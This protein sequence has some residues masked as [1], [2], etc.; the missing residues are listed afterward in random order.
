MNTTDAI[1]KLRF[2]ATH[3]V[4]END[5]DDA[6]KTLDQARDV[7]REVADALASLPTAQGEP[8][9]VRSLEWMLDGYAGSALGGYKVGPFHGGWGW[10]RGNASFSE[11]RWAETASKAKAAAQAEYERRILSA[12]IAPPS[13]AVTA[14]REALSTCA[15][16]LDEMYKLGIVYT[17]A[18]PADK[19]E[20][21][22]GTPYYIGEGVMP[23][24]RAA[25]SHTTGEGNP[26]STVPAK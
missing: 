11:D 26:A 14:L 3:L 22:V 7:M 12:I 1:E 16:I 13:P 9:A 19:F 5:L 2:N 25:L 15:R 24:I 21:V 8:V 4:A 17:P 10:K 20:G 18:T 23:M 6:L